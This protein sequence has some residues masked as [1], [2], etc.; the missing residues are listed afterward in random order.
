MS[1]ST[2]RVND[3]DNFR[4]QALKKG[5]ISCFKIRVTCSVHAVAEGCSEPV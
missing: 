3:A 1:L 2:S 5:E 4:P